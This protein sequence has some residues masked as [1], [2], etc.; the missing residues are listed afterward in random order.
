[1]HEPRYMGIRELLQLK[2]QMLMAA[3]LPKKHHDTAARWPKPKRAKP[4]KAKPKK[5]GCRDHRRKR[6]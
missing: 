3:V 6:G 1:M 4:K 2:T 5:L